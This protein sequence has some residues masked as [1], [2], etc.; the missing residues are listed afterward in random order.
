MLIVPV[1]LQD[2]EV[3]R[4]PWVSIAIMALMVAGFAILGPPS[5]GEGWGDRV[6]GGIRLLENFLLEHPYLNASPDV[7]PL[8][9]TGARAEV[10]RRREENQAHAATLPPFVLE[11]QEQE[12]KTLES[13]LRET[14]GEAPAWRYGFV[15]AKPRLVDAVTSMFLHG[16]WLHLVGNLLFFFA[17]GPFLEDVYGRVLFTGLYFS[18]GVVAA[19]VQASQTPESCVPLIGASGAIAGVMGA[20]LVRLGTSRIRFVFLPI[21]FLPFIRVSFRMRAAFVLPLWFAGQAALAAEAPATSNVAFWAHIGGF[22]FGMASAILIK[23]TRLEERWVDPGIQ[24]EISWT[25][26]PALVRAGDARR[27]GDFATAAREIAMVLREQ[28]GNLDALRLAFDV[29]LDA[30]RADEAIGVADRLLALY[31]RQGEA[32]LARALVFDAMNRARDAFTPR[33]GLAAARFLEKE[34]ETRD[35]LSLDEEV[36]SRFPVDASALQALVRIAAIERRDGNDE[37]VERAFDRARRHPLYSSEWEQ[38][39]M[40]A[41]RRPESGR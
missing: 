21:V 41:R 38:A 6:E 20:F 34:G 31:V 7:E 13:Q 15:P 32:Q 35:A 9:S 3:R 24:K 1:G 2:S 28:P 40:A 37:G 36:A 23:V 8:L 29:A 39:L 25:Q 26:H 33:F 17:T 30:G 11:G 18:S 4:Q 16:G 19:F 10:R 12:L 5:R 27:F 14:L 22:V